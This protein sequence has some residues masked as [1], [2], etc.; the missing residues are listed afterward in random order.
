METLNLIPEKIKCVGSC[1]EVLRFRLAM[2]HSNF[3]SFRC[4]FILLGV[5]GTLVGSFAVFWHSRTQCSGCVPPLSVG[6]HD[7][8][9]I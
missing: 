6:L 9:Q 1:L 4:F 7:Y 5:L 3:L 8:V 2:L